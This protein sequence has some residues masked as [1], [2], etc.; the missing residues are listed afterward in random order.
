MFSL[1]QAIVKDVLLV[2]CE[3]VQTVLQPD[4]FGKL[5]IEKEKKMKHLVPWL[6]SAVKSVRYFKIVFVC[7]II[8]VY[9]HSYMK[10]E[11]LAK[12]DQI[13]IRFV[14]VEI[15]MA[16]FVLIR[17]WQ[18]FNQVHIHSAHFSLNIFIGIA[19]IVF[20]FKINIGAIE[21]VGFSRRHHF[22]F[23]IT[24]D[25]CSRGLY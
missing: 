16:S 15:I 12:S 5:T 14:E 4:E 19:S 25:K 18:L 6:P 23:E 10:F 22:T 8:Q 9:Y 24:F 21:Q 13:K 20:L 11:R 17:T 7:S 2:F 1:L 3:M